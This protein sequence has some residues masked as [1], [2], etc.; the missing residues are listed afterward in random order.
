MNDHLYKRINK[1]EDRNFQLRLA[2]SGLSGAVR[3]MERLTEDKSAKQ[4]LGSVKIR[5]DKALELFD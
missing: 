4:D 1:L 5:L 3:A 2:I